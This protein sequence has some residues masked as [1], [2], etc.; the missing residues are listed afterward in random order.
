MA[1]KTAKRAIKDAL[2]DLSK[3]GFERFVDALLDRRATPRVRR[4]AVE[5]ASR[6]AVGDVLVETFTEA[7]A[8]GVVAE[9]LRGIDCHQAADTLGNRTTLYEA[10]LAGR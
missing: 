6:L 7:G 1:P 10:V 2:E 5:A 3:A 4:S 8:P 9:L